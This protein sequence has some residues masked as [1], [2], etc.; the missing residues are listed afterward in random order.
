[1]QV[2]E[3]KSFEKLAGCYHADAWVWS[4]GEQT[5]TGHLGI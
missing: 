1:M 4:Y 5:V 2:E 3:I